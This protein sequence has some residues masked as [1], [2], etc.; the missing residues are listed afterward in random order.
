MNCV[1]SIPWDKVDSLFENSTDQAGIVIGLYRLI[2]PD[3]DRVHHL[4]GWPGINP[5]DSGI[6]MKKFMAFDREH[7]PDRLRGGAWMNLGFRSD[8]NVGRGFVAYHSDIL[9]LKG[10]E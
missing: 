6:L 3:W 1:V 10:D 2:I 7:H 5:V 9:I 8:P 4:D